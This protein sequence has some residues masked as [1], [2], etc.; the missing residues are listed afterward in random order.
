MNGSSLVNKL[1][2]DGELVVKSVVNP[3]LMM[4][5]KLASDGYDPSFCFH[6]R[7]NVGN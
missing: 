7:V 4:V 2:N 1:I 5:R 3:W 6:Q